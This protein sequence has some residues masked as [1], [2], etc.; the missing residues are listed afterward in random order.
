ML[1]DK[2]Y[3]LILLIFFIIVAIIIIYICINCNLCKQKE[4][5]DD[6][7]N[8]LVIC[9]TACKKLKK[10]L[11]RSVKSV[12]MY[13]NNATI[14]IFNNKQ[15]NEK[16]FEDINDI[17]KEKKGTLLIVDISNCMDVFDVLLPLHESRTCYSKFLMPVFF[18][19][20]CENI[21]RIL[22]IDE[23]TVCTGSLL[24][25]LSTNIVNDFG[26]FIDWNKY[27]KDETITNK[28]ITEKWFDKN[29]YI[30][31]GVVVMKTSFDISSNHF[32][33]CFNLLHIITHYKLPVT[34]HDQFIFNAYG[35][36][37][38]TEPDI[39]NINPLT[40][41]NVF[42]IISK[43]YME[44]YNIVHDWYLKGTNYGFLRFIG[45]NIPKELM[46]SF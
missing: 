28:D 42:S 11:M 40:M 8:K 46:N 32:V 39:S 43:H 29:N 7:T 25:L 15:Y 37:I 17:V 27:L 5:F 9:Y 35:C 20:Y 14:V 38:L 30:C 16:D 19:E 44:K 4:S 3:L 1:N 10:L 23:D 24:P 41:S 22:Y 33:K 45:V 2:K 31:S 34:T 26:A 18:K 13:N 36:D 12:M 6:Q 21:D